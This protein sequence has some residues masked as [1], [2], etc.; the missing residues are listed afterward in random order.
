VTVSSLYD[1]ALGSDRPGERVLLRNSVY[2][3]GI[4]KTH[5]IR[6]DADIQWEQA[7]NLYQFPDIF[8]YARGYAAPLNDRAYRL[9]VNY[10][11]P[12]LYP[13]FGILGITY[14]KRIR[15]NGF[16]DYSQYRI[17]AFDADLREQSVGGQLFFDNVWLN[18]QDLTVG[19]ELAYRLD[20]DIFSVDENDVQFRLLV[21]GSF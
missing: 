5:G 9:G 8:R 21:S 3:P 4:F 10:Q 13:D 18:T 7:E 11:L 6:L 14:F 17:D 2:V 1:R 19:V 16:Y 20:P 12:L 15:L